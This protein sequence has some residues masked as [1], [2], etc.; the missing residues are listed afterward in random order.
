MVQPRRSRHRAAGDGFIMRDI[1]EIIRDF[2][3]ITFFGLVVLGC[4]VLYIAWH[5]GILL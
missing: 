4:G 1:I 3:V 2:L 5:E